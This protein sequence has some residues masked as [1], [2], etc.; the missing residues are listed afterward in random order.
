MDII[1]TLKDGTKIPGTLIHQYP[2]FE[3]GMRY[4]FKTSV[5]EIRCINKDGK[6]VEYV[7]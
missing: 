5:G 7:A 1:I 3:G 4:V 2:A 6:Y